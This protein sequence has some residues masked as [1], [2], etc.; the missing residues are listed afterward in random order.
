MRT[1]CG[2]ARRSRSPTSAPRRPASRVIRRLPSGL[3]TGFGRCRSNRAASRP[4][5]VDTS[6]IDAT[7]PATTN[8]R[9]P[10]GSRVLPPLR[11]ADLHDLEHGARPR[12][13]D[14]NPVATP[15]AA[16]VPCASSHGARKM[17]PRPWRRTTVEAESTSQT[18]R[19]A[20]PAPRPR[21]VFR[22][23]SVPRRGPTTATANCGP[24]CVPAR[25][26]V[27]RRGSTR[28]RRRLVHRRGCAV[29]A[30]PPR[31]VRSAGR[32]VRS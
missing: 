28:R 3:N 22:W 25:G 24:L 32:T 10:S 20:R 6:Q 11:V 14:P 23:R 4:P 16:R 5:T 15:V 17:S 27:P 30:D 18:R 13:P 29:L 31:S 21:L 8:R 7:R 1:R 26:D 9:V 19:P 2:P 12:V